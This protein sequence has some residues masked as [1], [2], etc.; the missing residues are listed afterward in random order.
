MDSFRIFPES[1]G[2]SELE[3]AILL[4]LADHGQS[5]KHHVTPLVCDDRFQIA[6]FG[7]HPDHFRSVILNET[8][9]GTRVLSA[10]RPRR[11]SQGRGPQ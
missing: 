11:R 9:Y 2:N 6:G 1:T 8:R 4:T 7:T 5:M 3:A 10:T